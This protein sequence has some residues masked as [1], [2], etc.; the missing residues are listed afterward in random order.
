MA[1]STLQGTHALRGG[2]SHSTS[3]TGS[4]YRPMTKQPQHKV[5]VALP[6]DHHIRIKERAEANE[7][8]VNGQIRWELRRYEAERS[9]G[10]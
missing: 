10:T 3:H 2:R 7:R 8:S 6:T 5:L 1:A 4:T 9:L